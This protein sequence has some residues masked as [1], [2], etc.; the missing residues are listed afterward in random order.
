MRKMRTAAQASGDAADLLEAAEASDPT[1]ATHY[2]E[3]FDTAALAC[4]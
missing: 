1:A 2:Q 4:T 3:L